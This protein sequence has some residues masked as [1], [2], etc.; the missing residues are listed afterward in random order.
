LEGT[1]AM[2]TMVQPFAPWMRDLTRFFTQESAVG[3]F[4]PPADVLVDDEGVSVYMD[5]PGMRADNLEIE[6]EGDLLSI[7]GE[8]PYPYDNERCKAMRI[9]RRFG[10]FERTLRVPQGLDPDA[11]DAS[12]SDG[13][14]SLRVPQPQ[15]SQPRKIDIKG[16]GASATIEASGSDAGADQQA[17]QPAED[18]A[19]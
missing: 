8:R 11:I 12:M 15:T 17:G 10:R 4:I 9:E 7:R 1:I 19:A 6:L 5:V 3:A 18:A 14:L 16:N 13:V 2:A